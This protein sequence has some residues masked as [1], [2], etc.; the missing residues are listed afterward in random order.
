MATKKIAKDNMDVVLANI[1]K[2]M[3]N[4]GAKSKFARFGNIE[5]TS[6][7]VISFGIKEVDE[8][9]YCG[10]V[11]RGK[12]VELFGPP[13]SGKSLLS[14]YLMAEAQ[15]QGLEA[16]LIDV[17]Q[18][19]DPEWAAS[20]GLDVDRLVFSNDFAS[21]ENALE[22]AYQ[23]V[24]SGA[25]G[26]VVIDS[27]A[28]LTP[29]AEIEGT[30]EGNARVGAQA[31]LM[32][33]GCRKIMSAL[34]TTTCVFI[35]QLR[36]KIGVRYGNP[37]TTPGGKAL[38]FYSHQR[39]R[40][41]QKGNIKVSEGGEDKIVGQISTVTFVKN[42]TARPF[43]KCEFK[44]IFDKDSLNPVVM[45]ANALKSAKIVSVYKG[46]FNI[47]KGFLDKDKIV[48]GTTTMKELAHYFIENDLVLKLLDILID[49]VD[50]DHDFED[51]NSAILE[52]RE[53]PSKIV[54]PLGD[55]E[56]SAS[57]VSDATAEELGNDAK[58]ES[59]E[60]E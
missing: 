46:I 48:T 1:E 36:E 50:G 10:G 54:S 4:R 6:V 44:I 17:E 53:D 16:A 57:K 45:L 55:F 38:K 23:L 26:I 40:V 21:G 43:G 5:R 35:N 25:F 3:G 42:K 9:S 18:S 30:L 58:E 37:E 32:S 27:T 20:H 52:M 15:R 11:P 41:A 2:S 28:A 8:A 24:K 34:G 60:D 49:E 47:K 33:R 39:C 14:I 59:L 13:S 29:L 51:L 56:I 7:P 12:M 31:Q 22:Y 19:F